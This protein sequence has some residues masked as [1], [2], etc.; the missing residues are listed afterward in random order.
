VVKVIWQEESHDKT[1]GGDEEQ[2][3]SKLL[4]RGSIAPSQ[5]FTFTRFI[6]FVRQLVAQ[7]RAKT[8]STF[9]FA[10]AAPS[11]SLSFGWRVT[12]GG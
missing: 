7:L 3:L 5:V 4:R 1:D 9:A 2:R 10:F 11:I 6:R 12:S 8:S